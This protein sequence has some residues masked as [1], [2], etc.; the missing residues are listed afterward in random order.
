LTSLDAASI[1]LSHHAASAIG[2]D[3]LQRRSQGYV[4]PD[5]FTHGSSAQRMYWFKLGLK[6]GSI[7]QCNTFQAARQ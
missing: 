4:T 6:T 7:G 3:R 2:D 1:F 5:S